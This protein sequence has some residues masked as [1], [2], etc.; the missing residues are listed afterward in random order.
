[1]KWQR[2]PL[3]GVTVVELADEQAEYCGLVFAGLGGA[4]VIKVEPPSGN[5]TRNIGPY[6]HDRVDPEHSLY[7]WN[8]NRGKRSVVIDIETAEGQQQLL[9]LLE[10]ADIFLDSTAPGRLAGTGLEPDAL[11]EKLPPRLIHSR[12][13]P[14]SGGKRAPPGWTTR[15][16]TWSTWHW[17]GR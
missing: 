1:M 3:S 11:A 9:S 10:H 4:D 12:M 17:V 15:G 5:S 8:Y 16:R 13:T 14:P 7:F 2:I 6:Y